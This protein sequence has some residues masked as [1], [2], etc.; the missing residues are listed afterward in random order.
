MMDKISSYQKIKRKLDDA[1]KE[2]ASMKARRLR[3]QL[4]IMDYN[5]MLGKIM[6]L[7]RVSGKTF[8]E[9]DDDI[10]NLMMI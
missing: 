2:I 3:E 7:D 9:F 4:L 8:I 5:I 6:V 10:K 1:E